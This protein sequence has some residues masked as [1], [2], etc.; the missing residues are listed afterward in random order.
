MLAN[1]ITEAISDTF[2]HGCP[3]EKAAQ[4]IL[5]HGIK[6]RD[7]ELVG[8]GQ[9][10]P[11][12]GK[13]YLTS[14]LRYSVIYAL[15]GDVLGSKV[16]DQLSKHFLSMGQFGYVF[17]VA[18]VE[19]GNLDPDEDSVGETLSI[20]ARPESSQYDDEYARTLKQNPQFLTQ[21]S[22][23]VA[24]KATP[25]QVQ[26][27]RNGEYAYAS[28]AGKRAL[29][30][31]PLWMKQRLLDLGAHAAHEGRVSVEKAWRVDKLK[32]EQLTKDGS[33]FFA[34]AEQVKLT[35]SIDG[36]PHQVYRQA[37]RRAVA[38]HGSAKVSAAS[39]RLPVQEHEPALRGETEEVELMVSPM[40]VS[41]SRS[42][43]S[44][45]RLEA[46]GEAIDQVGV[47][48]SGVTRISVQP[49]VHPGKY[50]ISSDGNHRI[51]ALR[52]RGVDAKIPVVLVR[53]TDLS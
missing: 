3:D 15:G 37:M 27:A 10:A 12:R 14:S 35:E 44:V 25:R 29:K 7:V 28:A 1:L 20:A 5:Q 30:A 4:Q 49:D 45:A 13:V 38:S 6:P 11:V 36:S 26:R 48:A 50:V 17:Q 2:Y 43:L 24:S 9:L 53:E 31:M 40:D 33:N 8:K 47:K 22:A 18:K 19:V 51:A 39:L 23:F 21:V 32:A 52:I 41:L 46:A 42:E 16:G 34:V